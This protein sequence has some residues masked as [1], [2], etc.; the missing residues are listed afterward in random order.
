MLIKDS[1]SIKIKDIGIRHGEKMHEVLLGSEEKSKAEDLDKYFKVP[2]D[3]RTLDYQIYF[4]KGQTSKKGLGEFTSKNT[5]QLTAEE[6]AS[7]IE[8]LPEF[9]IYSAD[10][11]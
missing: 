3:S 8:K 7:M 1:K 11:K 6:L 10:Q 9:K 2:I 5:E 4:E